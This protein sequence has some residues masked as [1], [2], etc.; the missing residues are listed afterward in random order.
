MSERGDG[1][2]G[3]R[4]VGSSSGLLAVVSSDQRRGAEVFATDL[5][6]EL[7]TRGRQVRTVALA[8]AESGARLDLITLGRTRLGLDTLRALRREV[9][10]AR[11]VV[12]HGSHT[13]PAS[14]L[15]TAG[16][17]TPFVYRTIGDPSYWSASATRRLR[18]GLLLRRARAVTVLWP[19]AAE[20]LA[21]RH[22][23]PAAKLR[24]I[25]NGVP[26]ARFPPL[27]DAARRAARQALGL[28]DRPVVLY[29]GALSAEK[30]VDLAV[31]A[32][33]GLPE[34]DLVVCGSGPQEA[35]MRG[36][37][38]EVAPGRVRFLTA[39]SQPER[40]LPAAD[41]LVLPSHSEGMPGVLIEAGLSQVP[42]VATAVGGVSEVVADGKTGLLVPPGNVGAL[43]GA[44]QDVLD[45]PGDLGRAARRH[46]LARFEMAIVATQWDDLLSELGA[47]D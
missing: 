35:A 38:G 6:D 15:S 7:L 22:R 28:G 9:V 3:D 23:V 44:L 14:A 12:A 4:R 40:L 47:F 31:R 8:P 2:Q 42:V 21:R 1:A 26:A 34:V 36:L 29:L 19:G 45:A 41:V 25:P 10:R 11:L 5:A 16:T 20:C 30:G 27:D 17:R 37:A 33:A 46:C 32:M 39:T 24:V 13:L 18:T 43:T